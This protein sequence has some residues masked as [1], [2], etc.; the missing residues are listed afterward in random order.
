MRVICNYYNSCLEEDC[1]HIVEHEETD[2]CELSCNKFKEGRS[3]LIHSY[4]SILPLRKLKLE[5]L[6]ESSL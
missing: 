3:I 2:C 6:N 5:K 1:N 4:C